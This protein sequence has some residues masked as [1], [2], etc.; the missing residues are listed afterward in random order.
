MAPSSHNT[1]NQERIARA[2]NRT[3]GCGYQKAL[4]RVKAAAAA[5][6]LPAKLDQ[7]GREEAVRTLTENHTQPA[8]VAVATSPSAD[9]QPSAVTLGLVRGGLDK[10]VVVTDA[11]ALAAQQG[12]RVLPVDLGEPLTELMA[13]T[14]RAMEAHR[15]LRYK[16][17]VVDAMRAQRDQSLNPYLLPTVPRELA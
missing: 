16:E 10:T 17:R 7:A 6:Q 14:H 4:Q 3:T 12:H 9:T 13:E 11:G 2:L 8:P 5:G 15:T 1:T